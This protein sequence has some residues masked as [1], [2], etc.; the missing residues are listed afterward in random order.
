MRRLGRRL[1]REGGFTIPEVLVA[2]VLLA[3]GAVAVMGVVDTSTRNTYR[4]EQTQVAINRAQQELESLRQLDYGQVALTSTPA[5]ATDPNDP[6]YRVSGNNF[7]TD[8]DPAVT[9]NSEMVVNGVSG[10]AGGTIAPGPT[11]FTSGDVHGKVYRFV[12]WQNDP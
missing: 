5:H 2:I 11:A 4:A 7:D 10:V 6:T 3:T 8:R 9:N 1:R 12:V